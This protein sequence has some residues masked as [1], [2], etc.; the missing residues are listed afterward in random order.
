MFH[1]AIVTEADSC[2]VALSFKSASLQWLRV[3]YLRNCRG[4]AV[5]WILGFAFVNLLL[6]EI[7]YD[8]A[9]ARL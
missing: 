9:V 2:F 1:L 3:P 6:L 8:K 5:R 7:S 4:E